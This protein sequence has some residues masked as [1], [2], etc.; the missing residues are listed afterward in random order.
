MRITRAEP[1]NK[2]WGCEEIWA[3]TDKYVGKFLRIKPGEM[4]SLQ[5]HL[6]KDET[7]H[8]LEGCPTVQI[9]VFVNEAN[10]YPGWEKDAKI[11]TMTPGATMHIA[12]G[13]VHRISN[14]FGM[15]DAVIV[16]VS[17]TELDDV[18]RLDDKYGRK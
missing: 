5:Y 15:K 13:T 14:E 7:L 3:H 16:E 2:P 8:C 12:P 1:I 17:T 9:G 11:Y 18:V 4:L 6:K 10:D